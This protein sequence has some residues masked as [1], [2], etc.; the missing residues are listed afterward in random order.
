MKKLF[1]ILA[2]I[3]V[4]V[5]SYLAMKPEE[6]LYMNEREILAYLTMGLEENSYLDENDVQAYTPTDVMDNRVPHKKKT[7]YYAVRNYEP[8]V[9]SLGFSI[10]PPPGSNWFEKLQDDSLHY[11]KV[12]KAHKRYVIQ[13]EAREVHL[14]KNLEAPEEIQNYVQQEK[15]NS[16]ALPDVKKP[17]L[18]VH[19]EESF[20]RKCVRYHQ[21]YQDHGVKGLSKQR[22]VNVD[23][24][25]LF[26]L[27][28]NNGSVAI[29]INYVEKSLSNTRV[30]SYSSEGETFLAS[31]TFH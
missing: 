19:I 16:V 7:P 26:C 1:L 29:D 30:T 28:P 13:S 15:N 20:S 8:R 17:N 25:G 5:I 23:T 12:N 4:C 27:H 6:T 10:V 9:S 11:V 22:Y 2:V 18:T 31:L 21:H 14:G 24:E 3:T